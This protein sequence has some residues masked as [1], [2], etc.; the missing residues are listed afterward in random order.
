[1][2]MHRRKWDP[3]PTA[4]A[5]VLLASDG[6][7]FSK[8]SIRRAYELAAGQ[9]IAVLSILKIYGSAFG[10]PNPGLLP[11][12]RERDEQLAHVRRAIGELERRGCSVDGQVAATRSSG[13][14]IARVARAR[15][16]SHVVMNHRGDQAGLRR[17][18][19][20]NVT[21]TLRRRLG[22]RVALEVVTPRR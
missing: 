15:G 19:Q 6:T 20:G 14:A 11:T 12:R 5:T 1:M 10:L 9:P 8:D 17:V 2:F 21:D 18:V 4:P 22:D 13:R 16:V 7:A 3:Q